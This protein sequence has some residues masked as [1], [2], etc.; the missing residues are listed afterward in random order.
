[1]NFFKINEI[2]SKEKPY[3]SKQVKRGIFVELKESWDDFLVLPM[4]LRC[5]LK[6]EAPLAIDAEIFSSK[7]GTKKAL[8][9]LADGLLIEAVLIKNGVRN[10]ICVSSQVGCPLACG[11]CLTGSMGFKRNLS[12]WEII[13]QVLLFARELKKENRKVTNIVFMG[14]GE[15]FLNYNNVLEAITFLNDANTFG[16][17]GRR[18]SISTVGI[19]DGIQKLS[20]E[21]L[22]INLAISLHF[23]DDKLRSS[24]MPI[25]NKYPIKILMTEAIN[26]FKKT[27]R[28]V[29]IE[30]IMIDGLNDSESMALKLLHLTSSLDCVINLIP[31]NAGGKYSASKKESIDR[32]KAILQNGGANVTVRFREGDDVSAACGQL[33]TS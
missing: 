32:F 17:S 4:S 11:F 33:A 2:L 18:F 28:K 10:T 23:S 14:M 26:Y 20:N 24:F 21:K 8:I 22:Q 9:R 31:C 27:G 29:M 3:R 15:P 25:N 7:K 5:Q 19:P 13:E 6:K 12:K 30:Y 1:M 16:L